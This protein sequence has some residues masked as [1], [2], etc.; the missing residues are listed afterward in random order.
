MLLIFT[1]FQPILL[2]DVLY[3]TAVGGSPQYPEG[4]KDEVFVR[5]PGSASWDVLSDVVDNVSTD[6]SYTNSYD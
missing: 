6:Y 4:S 2:Q 3:I 1:H 5:C